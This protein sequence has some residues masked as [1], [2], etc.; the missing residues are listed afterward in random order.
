MGKNGGSSAIPT[1]CILNLKNRCESKLR[2]N[3]PQHEERQQDRYAAARKPAVAVT[4]L[5]D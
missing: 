5:S 3:A 4:H 1:I 2:F